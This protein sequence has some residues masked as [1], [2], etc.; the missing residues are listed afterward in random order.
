[1]FENLPLVR[2]SVLQ[3]TLRISI[4][5]F[6]VSEQLEMSRNNVMIYTSEQQQEKGLKFDSYNVIDGDYGKIPDECQCCSIT[7]S[8]GIAW[9]VLNLS[10]E[11]LIEEIRIIGRSDG[12]LYFS[13]I[14]LFRFTNQTL[15]HRCFE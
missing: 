4:V 14:L 11:Y 1:M 8:S 12:K 9:L 7:F 15:K 2:V 10:R 5:F 3:L 13:C 6:A